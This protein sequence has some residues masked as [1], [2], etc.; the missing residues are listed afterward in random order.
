MT[1]SLL[2]QDGTK[3]LDTMLSS[4][5]TVEETVQ[6]AIDYEAGK[7]LPQFKKGPNGEL[8]LDVPEPEPEPEPKETGGDDEDDESD[9]SEGWEG[10]CTHEVRCSSPCVPDPPPTIDCGI[11]LD[12]LKDLIP[13]M[14]PDDKPCTWR[15]WVDKVHEVL[16]DKGLSEKEYIDIM[17]WRMGGDFLKAMKRMRKE[18]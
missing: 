5:A 1:C 2:P 10:E 14:H 3:M 6:W 18:G 17:E 15:F 12:M 4:T 13:F 16:D 7:Q 9:D 8:I 11:D